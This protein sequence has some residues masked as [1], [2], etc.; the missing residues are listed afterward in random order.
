VVTHGESGSFERRERA[1]FDPTNL[2][3]SRI[4]AVSKWIFRKLIEPVSLCTKFLSY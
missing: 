4:P 3:T 1:D 2:G